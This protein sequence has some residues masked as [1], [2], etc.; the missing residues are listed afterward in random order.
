MIL[1]YKQI[2]RIDIVTKETQ[3]SPRH[4]WVGWIAPI[5]S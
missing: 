3:E 4:L 5:N 2:S 1:Y